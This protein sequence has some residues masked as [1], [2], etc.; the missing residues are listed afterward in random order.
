MQMNQHSQPWQTLWGM[1]FY[2]LSPDEAAAW[3]AEIRAVIRG[4]D[5]DEL[6]A[7]IRFMSKTSTRNPKL[8]DLRRAVYANRRGYVM[9]EDADKPCHLCGS[10]MLP[11]CPGAHT[12]E[13]LFW[14]YA[15]GMC[16]VPCTCAAGLRV[17]SRMAGLTEEQR[18]NLKA[19]AIRAVEQNRARNDQISEWCENNG[20]EWRSKAVDT[21]KRFE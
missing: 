1:Y 14:V 13:E 15:P 8:R 21:I 10:G 12:D 5:N 17:L 18:E 4:V 7:A 2:K 11:Y 6:V 9:Q 3:D 16:T 20:Y 19:M